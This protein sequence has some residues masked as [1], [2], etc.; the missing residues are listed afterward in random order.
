M[1]AGLLMKNAS[2]LFLFATMLFVFT[3]GGRNN[4]LTEQATETMQ[5]ETNQVDYI[6]VRFHYH[7]REIDPN[8]YSLPEAF[9]YETVDIPVANFEEILVREF[10]ERTGIPI[11]RIW[12]SD[13][14]FYA[15]RL[16]VNLGEGARN[17]FDSRG[18]SGSLIYLTILHKNI[19]NLVQDGAYEVLINWRVGQ[20]GNHFSFNGIFIVENSETVDVIWYN[21]HLPDDYV[22]LPNSNS[23]TIFA[24]GIEI[25]TRLFTAHGEIYYTHIPL[26]SEMVDAFGWEIINTG[27]Q[28][29]IF[30]NGESLGEIIYVNYEYFMFNNL[31][32]FDVTSLGVNDAFI[33]LNRNRYLPL[34]LFTEM[35]Y[36]V[37]IADGNVH[38]NSSEKSPP[39]VETQESS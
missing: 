15:N 6:P 21:L 5:P 4:E 22:T 26:L 24:D 8:I 28:S 13:C 3:A 35:G 1:G 30:R 16:H 31:H 9:L 11:M 2:L 20:I 19:A 33:S 25:A 14:E 37:F 18:S 38:I 39:Y 17:F 10:Y 7:S 34:S 36:E 29:A 23:G 32:R 12:F 27:M